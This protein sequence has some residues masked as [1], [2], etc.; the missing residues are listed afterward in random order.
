MEWVKV[1][2]FGEE[3]ELRLVFENYQD[4]NNTAIILEEYNEEYGFFEEY[5]IATVN[6]ESLKLG[7]NFVAIK[8]Y[9]ENEGV[10]EA[11]IEAG[12]VEK[13]AVT[14][15]YSGFVELPVHKLTDKAIRVRDE[16]LAGV[17]L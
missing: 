16:Q 2:S 7:E 6:V 12:I 8:N 11:L 15:A 10:L 1:N 17:G 3:L 14:I 5:F 9:S 4:G 13:E